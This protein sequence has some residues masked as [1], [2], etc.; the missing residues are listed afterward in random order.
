MHEFHQLSATSLQGQPINFNDFE[1]KVVLIVNTASKCGFTYQYESLQAL[2]NKYA[3][4]GLVILGFP[5]N[6]FGQQE[7][8]GATQIEQ[9]CLINF[10][11]SFLMAAKVDVNGEHAHP[12]F[13]YLK[14]ALPGF[15]TRKIKWNF[16]K[17]LIAADGMPIK[18]YAPFT[19]PKKLEL[20]I[21]KALAQAKSTL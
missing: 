4:Q 19:K 7:P 13:R 1:G 20:T 15:L 11:V 16:T 8:G 18:R 2:H 3:S 12:V 17:F 5:C 10:G 14:S 6:Q 9:G 21:Q